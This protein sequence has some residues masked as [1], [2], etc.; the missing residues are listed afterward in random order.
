M[1]L[2]NFRKKENP[3]SQP[4]FA[5]NNQISTQQSIPTTNDGRN[6][7]LSEMVFN[8]IQDGVIVIDSNRVIKRMNPAA[9]RLT[10]NLDESFALGLD[11]A[12]IFR[13]ENEDGTVVSNDKNPMLNA[14]NANQEFRSRKLILSPKDTP[15]KFPIEVSVIPAKNQIGDKVITFRNIE[16]EIAEEKEQSEFISTA[17]HEMRTPVA[18]IEGYLGLALNPQTATIDERAK[19]YLESARAS[20][21]HLGKLFQ[22]LLDVTK[23]DDKKIKPRLIPLDLTEYIK[24]LASEYEPKFREKQINYIFGANSLK[25]NNHELQQKILTAADINFL[26]EIMSNIIENAIKY[27]PQGG[28]ISINVQADENRGIISVADTGIGIPAEDLQHIFQKFYRVDNRQTREIGGTGLGLYLVKQRTEAMGG[29][30]WAESMFGKGSTFFIA[31]PRISVEEYEKRRII[32]TNEM[33]ALQNQKQQYSQV[34]NNM[35]K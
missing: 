18:S 12:L 15:N 32:L 9:T 11:I 6:S 23:L 33:Q 27:S 26:Q 3:I 22:D 28:S 20:S 16:K 30:V 13:L 29:T 8:T 17:S 24:K 21:Q 2:F 1:S 25:A 19:K 14:I 35:V 4:V 7:E 5:N 34:N 10:G 31:L